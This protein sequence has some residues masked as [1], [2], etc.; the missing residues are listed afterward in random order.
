MWNEG[1]ICA[2]VLTCGM[3]LGARVA[4][5]EDTFLAKVCEY[6]VFA[7]KTGVCL[8]SR[9]RRESHELFVPAYG[10][11]SGAFIYIFKRLR[12]ILRTHSRDFQHERPYYPLIPQLCVLPPLDIVTFGS[13]LAALVSAPHA[14][15]KTRFF[16][17]EIA[18]PKQPHETRAHTLQ[19]TYKSRTASVKC[20]HCTRRTSR[21]IVGPSIHREINT[22][23]LERG[24]ALL[25]FFFIFS[26]LH[27]RVI[28]A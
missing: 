7:T 18:L 19:Y 25:G 17:M 2:V 3:L 21:V 16:S 28:I 15:T 12:E 4:S 13:T 5:A 23:R 26:K 22:L 6:S 20:L 24:D 9:A 27:A 11:Y 14:K 8:F 10:G 1:Q